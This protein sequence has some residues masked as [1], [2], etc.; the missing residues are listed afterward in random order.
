MDGLEMDKTSPNISTNMFT[1]C[2]VF[3]KQLIICQFK[4][5]LFSLDDRTDANVLMCSEFNMNVEFCGIFASC[6]QWFMIRIC[7]QRLAIINS[8]YVL[9]Y[10]AGNKLYMH[11]SAFNSIA[12][13]AFKIELTKAN[14]HVIPKCSHYKSEQLQLLPPIGHLSCEYKC[15]RVCGTA[16]KWRIYVKLVFFCSF[17]NGNAANYAITNCSSA[18][19]NDKENVINYTRTCVIVHYDVCI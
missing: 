1:P 7:D 4:L 13:K 14:M 8:N 9:L 15:R 12:G 6:L 17:I 19:L 2:E 11:S 3:H 5:F 10:V 18:V 16:R